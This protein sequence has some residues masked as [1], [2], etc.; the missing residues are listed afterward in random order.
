MQQNT[1]IYDTRNTRNDGSVKKGTRSGE[2]ERFTS[3]RNASCATACNMGH[4]KCANSARRFEP[5]D[6]DTTTSDRE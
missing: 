5:A 2:S 1:N 3:A 6:L 4:M